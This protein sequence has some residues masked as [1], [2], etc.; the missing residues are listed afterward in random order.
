[1]FVFIRHFASFDLGIPRSRVPRA[2]TALNDG[3]RSG[4]VVCLFFI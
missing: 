3:S 4:V 2:T 1:V